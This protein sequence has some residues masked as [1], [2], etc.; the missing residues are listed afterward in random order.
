MESIVITVSTNNQYLASIIEKI[1]E[2]EIKS[3]SSLNNIY[4]QLTKEKEKIESPNY[5]LLE[6]YVEEIEFFKNQFN[7]LAIRYWSIR[8]CIEINK[9]TLDLWLINLNPP[10]NSCIEH[11]LI[12]KFAII[13]TQFNKIDNDI[14]NHAM[15]NYTQ[16]N[17]SNNYILV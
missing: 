9:N 13:L 17:V 2:I 10:T 7:I 1:K 3:N 16:L 6:T 4:E 14:F 8:I 11:S 15:S 12:K 5:N